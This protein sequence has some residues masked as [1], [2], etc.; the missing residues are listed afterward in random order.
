MRKLIKVEDEC[1]SLSRQLELNNVAIQRL[2]EV[3]FQDGVGGQAK[4]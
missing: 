4:P 3:V 2:N 1:R